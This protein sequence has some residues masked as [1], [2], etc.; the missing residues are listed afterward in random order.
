MRLALV[1]VGIR[2]R[3]NWAIGINFTKMHPGNIPI[4]WEKP[5][6]RQKYTGIHCRV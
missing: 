5:E 2:P 6:F 3:P 4:F 1:S